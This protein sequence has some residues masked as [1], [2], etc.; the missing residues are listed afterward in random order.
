MAGYTRVDT[1]NNIAD[2]NV[3]N[4]ADLDGE[5]DAIQAGFNSS[6]G[7]SHNGTAGNGA[8]I[9]ALGP[10]QDVTISTSVLGVKTT[11]TVDLGTTVLRFKDFYLAGNASL[12]ANLT[13]TGTGNR[14]TGDFSN[15]TV[16]S[17]VAFQTSTSNSNTGLIVLPNGTSTTSNIQ[18]FNNS[19]STNASGFQ[20]ANLSTESTIRSLIT[21]TGTYLPMTFYTGGSERARIDTSGNVGIGTTANNVFDQV[22]GARPLLVQKSDT[23]TTIAGS[24]ASITISNGDTTT[25]NTAQLNFAAITGA[26]A[27]Q[28]SSAVISAVFGARTN[29][30]YPTGQLVFST[31]TTLN[32]APTEKMRIDS[33]G[34]VGIGTASPSQ[35]LQVAGNARLG[36]GAYLGFPDSAGAFTRFSNGEFIA[37]SNQQLQLCAD[38]SDGTIAF[39]TTSTGSASNER[40]RIDSSGNVGIGTSSPGYKL[41]TYA[42]TTSLSIQQVIQN[43]NAG[44]GTAALGFSVSSASG[45]E[46]LV[47]KGGIGF[48]RNAAY[49]GGFMAFYNNNSGAAGDFTTAD[50]AMRIDNAKNVGIGT[51]SPSASAILDAQSTTKGVRMPNMTTTQKNAISSPAAG[52]MVFDT[53]L[54]KLCVYSGSAWQTITSV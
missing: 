33:S 37:T 38:N 40:M 51:T 19:D 13:F 45:G 18:F 14:I 42:S 17:R 2:G 5:F 36:T 43:S 50:E 47:V 15:A 29:G 3:I 21:G 34:N 7:H 31:S 41:N 46:G 27:N 6:T 16:A 1:I 4:A 23:S 8:P 53:T 10:A 26:S 9:L 25:S 11:N 28:Y 32:V 35:K 22:S 39:F 12:A 20:I 49:G 24:T 30:Q 44:S 54:A 52:L 48:Q